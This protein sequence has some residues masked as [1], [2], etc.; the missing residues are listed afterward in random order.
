M[1]DLEAY[2]AAQRV[3]RQTIEMLRQ[4]LRPGM[5]LVDVRALCE[6]HMRGLGAESF[7]YYGVGAFVFS[8][9]E[10]ARSVSGRD[11]ATSDR[12]IGEDDL[13][14]VDLSPQV[15][16]VWGDFARTLVLEGGQVRERAQDV[17]NP[18]WRG[19]LEAQAR[20]HEE[21]LRFAAPQMT[22][23]DLHAH[24][25]DCITRLGYANLDFHGNLGHTIERRLEDR[26]YLEP[27]S[28]AQLGEVGPFTFEPHIGLPG[29]PYGYKLEN[30]YAF[31][32]ERLCA[33]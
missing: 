26:L 25:S 4:T 21:L 24:M 3:A 14:T 19:G 20:L 1:Q 30:V 8:G 11:Y 27:G 12:L 33:L 18:A 5:R 9:D 6:A 23:S 28:G 2:I 16:G 10:T 7:W 17:Q 29:S 15:G 13:I 22:L 31:R 32:E